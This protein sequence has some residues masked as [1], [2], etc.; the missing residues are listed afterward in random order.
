MILISVFLK[1]FI[2]NLVHINKNNLGDLL[3]SFISSLHAKEKTKNKKRLNE[4]FSSNY[5]QN[6]FEVIA[7]FKM[8]MI[9]MII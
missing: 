7:N 6:K 2:Q 9:K 4:D 3:R 5:W 1:Y 8:K